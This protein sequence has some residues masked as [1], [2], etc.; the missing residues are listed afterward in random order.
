MDQSPMPGIL[1]KLEAHLIQQP[2]I[3]VELLSLSDSFTP[4]D[5]LIKILETS[6][7]KVQSVIKN[8]LNYKVKISCLLH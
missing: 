2:K 8:L 6:V 3:Q 7:D 1:A 4:D 5:S